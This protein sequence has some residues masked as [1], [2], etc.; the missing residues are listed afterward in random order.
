MFLIK[1][2]KVLNITLIGTLL[3]LTVSVVAQDTSSQKSIFDV[4]NYKEVL[5]VTLE[6]DF[7]E[8]DT[9]RRSPVKNKAV[10][11]FKDEMGIKQK[12]NVK[13]TARGKFR[14]LKCEMVP[15]KI[16]FKKKKLKV[17]GLAK[18]DDMKLVS[19]CVSNKSEAKALLQKEYLA[20]RLYN[21]LTE[22]SFR[23]QLL[24]ITYK[25]VKTG[26]KTKHWAFLIED[27]AQL[28]D[29]IGASETIANSLALPRDTFHSAQLKMASVFQYM[30]GNADWNLGVG[31][32]VKYLIKDGKVLPIPYD[33]DFSGLVDAPYAV[34][35]PNFGIPSVKTR[36]FLGF[37][38]D[39]GQ[40]KS[41]LSYF[42]VKRL[43][44]LK[45]VKNFKVLEFT[46]RDEVV[47]YLESFFA[48][49]ND[50]VLGEK[51][52]TTPIS[53]VVSLKSE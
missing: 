24:K 34:A 37:K 45:I 11:T 14:R 3:L 35:N 13:L 7:S 49:M 15:L 8:I 2:K 39:A 16:A 26:N 48:T 12:W 38:E 31:R 33:F 42:K 32:N 5:S 47:D 23:V 46:K 30:I 21:E 6:A 43:S 36:I 50:I 25:D 51:V 18:F 53:S 27:T 29:R 41:I 28:K 20:Y 52:E 19:H 9:S 22:N 44:L 4:M 17:A 1:L 40:L 10:L